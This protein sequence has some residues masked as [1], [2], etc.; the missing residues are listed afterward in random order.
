MRSDEIMQHVVN[1]QVVRSEIS[2]IHPERRSK[3]VNDLVTL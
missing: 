3:L 2:R 1:V